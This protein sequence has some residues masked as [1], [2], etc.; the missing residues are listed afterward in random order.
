M[1]SEPDV[2]RWVV[3][4][5]L[6]RRP[7]QLP[8]PDQWARAI[9]DLEAGRLGALAAHLLGS[10]LEQLPL[11]ARLHL[12]ATQS[13]ARSL[14]ARTTP[15]LVELAAAMERLGASW[16]ILKGLPLGYRLYPS[17][18]C[19][20][21][22]DIDILVGR[23]HLTGAETVLRDLGY[24]AA[25]R[26]DPL[27]HHR[28]YR[29]PCR[30]GEDL[31][32]LHW[33]A[34]LPGFGG[35]PPAIVLQKRREI[36]LDGLTIYVPGAEEERDLLLRHFVKHASAHA[37]LLL[38][39]LLHLGEAPYRHPLGG[40]VGDDLVR[41]GLPRSIDGPNRPRI[42]PLRRWLSH[43]TFAQRSENRKVTWVLIPGAMA[44]PATFFPWMWRQVLWPKE[45]SER[46][47]PVAAGPLGRYTWRLRRLLRWR[48]P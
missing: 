33:S 43:R 27:L 35:P 15:Q 38:D 19:R 47:R 32:E 22:R 24:H 2:I 25:S 14:V 26:I 5:A 46:W 37:I 13:R 7:P 3:H 6:G 28:E 1:K 4:T 40:L 17:P 20:P 48:V 8:A 44:S 36:A 23:E 9:G 31:V 21:A 29:R 30:D 18:A 34:H 41:L 12:Q 11:P 42:Y 39:L 45:P 10:D 16:L